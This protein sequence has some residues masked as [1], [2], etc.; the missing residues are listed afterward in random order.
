M[1][2]LNCVCIVTDSMEELLEGDLVLPKTRNAMKCFGAPDSCRWP[3]SSN[4]IVKVP[5]VV[6]DNYG[7]PI[8]YCLLFIKNITNGS[9]KSSE[10]RSPT[11]QKVTRRKPFGTP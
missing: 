5:Y 9:F 10:L 7:G 6:S 4:G 11:P 3:K 1:R 2:V 8:F